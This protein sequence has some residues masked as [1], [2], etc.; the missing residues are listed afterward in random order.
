MLLL[1][2]INFWGISE[3]VKLNATFT[4]V[5]LSGL[6][7][8]VLIGVVTLAS[9]LGDPSRAF[10]FQEG[11]SVPI[12]IFA[13]A[14]LAFYALIGFEDSVNVA[15]E[16][17]NPSRTYPRVLFGGLLLTGFIYLSLRLLP[18]WWYPRVSLSSPV[19]PCWRL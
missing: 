12:A 17:Q 4:I 18:R 19:A 7:L 16:T 2:L 15:E 3:S 9:G 5:E 11:R 6:V 1:A 13:G 10:E 14:A 8:I